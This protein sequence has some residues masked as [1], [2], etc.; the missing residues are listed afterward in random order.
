M[1]ILPADHR[2]R[3]GESVLFVWGDAPFWIVVDPEAA[4][5]LDALCA[6]QSPP[7]ARAGAPRPPPAPG[8]GGGAGGPPGGGGVPPPPRGAT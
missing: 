2:E 7:A 8:G 5:F 4:R 6:G 1:R 3:R